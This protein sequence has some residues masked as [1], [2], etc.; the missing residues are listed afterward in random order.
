MKIGFFPEKF[1]ELLSASAESNILN[2]LLDP[3]ISSD[4]IFS[5]ALVISSDAFLLNYTLFLASY[6]PYFLSNNSSSK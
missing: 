1:G 3:V 4:A 6:F 2:Y 5:D